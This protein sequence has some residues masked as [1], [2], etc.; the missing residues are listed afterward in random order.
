VPGL[1]AL[2][3]VAAA[4]SAAVLVGLGV[5]WLS[6]RVRPVALLFRI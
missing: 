4:L 1:P 3:L 5:T 6:L 2:V